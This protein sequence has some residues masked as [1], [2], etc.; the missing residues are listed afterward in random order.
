V[1]DSAFVWN[2][3]SNIVV[4]VCYSMVE[5]S[6]SISARYTTASANSVLYVNNNTIPQCDT[7]MNGTRSNKRPDINFGF[8]GYACEGLPKIINV[9]LIDVPQIDVAALDIISFTPTGNY[10]DIPSPI[11]FTLTNYGTTPLRDSLVI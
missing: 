2:G 4:Q 10:S 9:N 7:L 8:V 3:E 11:T 1:L 6:G 5:K